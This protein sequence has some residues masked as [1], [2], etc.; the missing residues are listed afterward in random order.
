MALV[1]VRQHVHVERAV[2]AV[3]HRPEQ[4]VGVRRVD[5][6]VD[7][8]HVLAGGA[9]QQRRAVER[10]PDFGLRHVALAN[11]RDHLADVGQRL[12]HRH[13]LDALDAERVAQEVQEQR[14]HAD[15]LDQAR[16]RGR[17]LRD[18]RGQDRVASA[19]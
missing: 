14:L 5:V 4:R 12:V 16:F 11:Q 19:A 8:D 13:P 3:R 6:V 2:G 9:V 18:D 17:H 1:A 7:R 10:A 15:A